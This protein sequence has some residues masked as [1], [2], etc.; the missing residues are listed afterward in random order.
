MFSSIV[1]VNLFYDIFF[2]SL[3]ASESCGAIF[4][5]RLKFNEFAQNFLVASR[6]YAN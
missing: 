1:L 6:I 4:I 2:F 3:F 5:W